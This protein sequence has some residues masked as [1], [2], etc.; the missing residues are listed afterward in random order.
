MALFEPGDAV[1]RYRVLRPLRLGPRH[2]L[3]LALA[4]GVRHVLKAPSPDNPHRAGV[5]DDMRRQFGFLAAAVCPVDGAVCYQEILPWHDTL[6][7]GMPYVDGMPVRGRLLDPTWLPADRHAFLAGLGRTLDALHDR[8]IAHRDVSDDNVLLVGDTTSWLL[9]F[10]LSVRGELVSDVTMSLTS[11]SPAFKAPEQW[12]GLP[13][14][15][16]VDVFAFGLLA[17]AVL[18]QRL[19]PPSSRDVAGQREIIHRLPTAPTVRHFLAACLLDAPANRPRRC[20][21][22]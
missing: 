1:G 11:G 16:R 4:N 8:S 17:L 13:Q 21:A 18:A 6:V 7:L 22:I 10:D 20:G 14:D 2:E 12:R 9:D 5:L 3:Y 19:A 15:S